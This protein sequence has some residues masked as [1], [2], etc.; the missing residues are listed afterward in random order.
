MNNFIEWT[1]LQFWEYTK[2]TF[3]IFRWLFGIIVL[4]ATWR[5]NR[6]QNTVVAEQSDLFDRNGQ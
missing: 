1:F 3:R 5:L 6:K 4:I 2:L